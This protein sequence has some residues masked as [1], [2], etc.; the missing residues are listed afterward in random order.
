[1]LIF[2]NARCSH[3]LPNQR[4]SPSRLAPGSAKKAK[5]ERYAFY[6]ANKVSMNK[7]VFTLLLLFISHFV[8]PI[9]GKCIIG[10]SEWSVQSECGGMVW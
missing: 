4:M 6:L 1:M 7:F 9:E 3:T 8:R 10:Q 5:L 2:I